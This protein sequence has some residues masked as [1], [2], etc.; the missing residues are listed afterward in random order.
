MEEEHDRRQH[1]RVK[2]QHEATIATDQGTT[3]G[4]ILDISLNGVLVAVG[5]SFDP[6]NTCEV[7]IPLSDDPGQVITTEARVV[8]RDAAGLAIHFEAMDLASAA[9]LRRLVSYNSDHPDRIEREAT[10]LRL[11]LEEGGSPGE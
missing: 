11:S 9:H 1:S 2:W 3:S 4:S 10:H 5:P 7:R 8:R 6:V